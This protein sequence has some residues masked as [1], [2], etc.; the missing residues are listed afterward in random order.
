MEIISPEQN[1]YIR[2]LRR[3]STI[4]ISSEKSTLSPLPLYWSALEK[5]MPDQMI[6]S[7]MSLR[8]RE[9]IVN[10][11]EIYVNSKVNLLAYGKASRLMYMAARKII[12]DKLFGRG[13][14]ITHEKP[15]QIRMDNSKEDVLMSSHPFITNRSVVAGRRAKEFV[16]SGNKND[17]LLALISGGG[18]AMLALP[19]DTIKIKD[20]IDFITSVMYMSVP[21]REV[22]VLKK[23]LSK[24]KGGRLA[25]ATKGKVIVNCILSDERNHE[26]S[27]ISSGM[28][29]CN[30]SINPIEV[31]D[32][33][34]LWDITPDNIKKTILNVK[35]EKNIGCSK[36]IISHIVGSRDNLINVMIEDSE[37]YGFDSVHSIENLHSCTP[38]YASDLLIKKF[39]KI[40]YSAKPGK[41]LVISTGEIQVKVDQYSNSKG[42]R[43]QHLVALF[44]LKFK[45]LFDFYFVAIATD[46]MDYLN[47]VHGAFYKSSMRKE[48]EENRDFIQTKINETNS[49]EIHK[50]LG[51]L[52][53]GSL[54]ATNVSD[55]F[56]FSFNKE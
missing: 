11:R 36:N 41:H 23:S 30:K 45:L 50:K 48:I 2:V 27:A 44:M 53:K 9:L 43:N 38:E 49:Y 29:V 16:E 12:G 31:M 40:Y 42:G 19:V 33:Y 39:Q 22:N 10:E 26:I 32:K 14:L 1:L 7:A 21:E 52:L 51:T 5:S 34:S 17:I 37:A 4:K 8:N 20:K 55:F 13:L 47:G 6:E 25:E 46:G 15:V 56:L 35:E 24:I 54:T 28:T 3:Y 18:S